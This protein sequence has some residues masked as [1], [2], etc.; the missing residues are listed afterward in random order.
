[1][2]YQRQLHP[3]LG[4]GVEIA[5][6]DDGYPMGLG[7]STQFLAGLGTNCKK[8]KEE[9]VGCENVQRSGEMLALA[10]AIKV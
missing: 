5:Q 8:K 9:W 3:Q 1:M 6:V 7:G 10:G 4:L 2:L